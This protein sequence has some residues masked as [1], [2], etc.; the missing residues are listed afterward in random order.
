M[1]GLNLIL[2]M[3]FALVLLLVALLVAP[4]AAAAEFDLS[5]LPA[6]KPE[7][8]VQGIIRIWGHDLLELVHAW[9]EAFKKLH[10]ESRFDD[11]LLTTPV[12]FSGLVAGNADIG[13]MGHSWW[14]SDLKGFEAV[15]GYP[16]LE[17]KFAQGSFNEPKGSTPSP[18]FFV[19]KDNPLTGLTL[20]QLDGI[21]GAERTGG[22]KGTKWTTDAARGPEKNVRTWG[23]LGLTG[24][25][26]DKPIHPYGID[27]V[28][29]NWSDLVH[30]VVF[31][32]GT[33][34]NPTMKEIV[35]GGVEAPA[36]VQLVQAV[37]RDRYAIAF[38]FQK[39][40]D[41]AKLDVRVLPL[42][43]DA[44]S[45]YVMPSAQSVHDN[46]YPMNNAPWLY[47]NRPPG[48]PLSPR[49][50]E[51]LRFVLSREGQQLVAKDRTWIPLSAES[52]AEQLKKLN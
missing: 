47:V 35:R 26:A 34:W 31:K 8:R 7:A 12:A 40:V 49:I 22:W 46:T 4:R 21:F 10:Y 48:K 20:E 19:H 42:A 38:S 11:Y 43:K 32:G 25:W 5:K 30:K 50:K 29:S 15:F 14:R 33:K 41:E 9:E 44:G 45:P 51:F 24:E 37:H 18:V 6:Y 39:V 17:I 27:G 2:P 36:D 16:P 52:A 28:L 1:S 23:Q 3:P 13:Y